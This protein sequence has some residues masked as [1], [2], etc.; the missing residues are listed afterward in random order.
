[1][2]S[3]TSARRRF[4]P[5][6]KA[7][8]SY[9]RVRRGRRSLRQHAEAAL[10]ETHG[11]DSERPVEAG[12]VVLPGDR[13]GQLGELASGQL[14]EQALPQGGVDVGRRAR[15]RLR[16]VEGGLLERREAL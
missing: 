2:A 16:Q 10:G 8:A 1:A 13:G 14:R 12:A 7:R 5:A 6:G 4:L 11:L 9:L 3:A 15:H